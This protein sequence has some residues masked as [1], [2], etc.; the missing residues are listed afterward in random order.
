MYKWLWPIFLSTVK[1]YE[2]AVFFFSFTWLIIYNREY[3]TCVSSVS[4]HYPHC[5]NLMQFALVLYELSFPC[6]HCFTYLCWHNTTGEYVFITVVN[7]VPSSSNLLWQISSLMNFRHEKVLTYVLSHSGFC[8]V[9][10]GHGIQIM[11]FKR[12]YFTLQI[13]LVLIS[14]VLKLCFS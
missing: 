10:F 6:H 11:P 14:V 3:M 13:R 7:P 1:L 4:F 12:A 5:S 9:L 8:H 2:H